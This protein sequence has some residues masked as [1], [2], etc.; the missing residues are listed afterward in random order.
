LLLPG[1]PSLSRDQRGHG[2][3]TN[4]GRAC[5]KHVARIRCTPAATS[6]SSTPVRAPKACLHHPRST[7]SGLPR[8]RH[9]LS[10]NRL[11]GVR[12]PLALVARRLDPT[13]DDP[14]AVAAAVGVAQPLHP[15]PRSS[16]EGCGRAR[17]RLSLSR[18][19]PSATNRL[20]AHSI[21]QVL[22]GITRGVAHVERGSTTRREEGVDR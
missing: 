2:G 18:H 1:R 14:V 17:R 9:S 6:T 22:C 5:A 11:E 8:T 21:S 3:T 10:A 13:G 20:R 15:Y 12:R 7:A 4:P 16:R 19:E